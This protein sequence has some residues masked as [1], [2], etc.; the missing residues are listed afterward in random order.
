MDIIKLKSKVNWCSHEL[1]SLTPLNE[2]PDEKVYKVCTEYNYE[3]EKEDKEIKAIHLHCGPIL[4]T[5]SIDPQIGMTLKEISSAY[6]S[7]GDYIY[8]ALIFKYDILG[9]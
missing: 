8:P 6:D 3:F 1:H 5:N 7:K 9:N 2:K 4:R